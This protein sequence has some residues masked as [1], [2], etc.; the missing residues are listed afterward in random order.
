MEV[1]EA[2]IMKQKLGIKA[3]IENSPH[4]YSDQWWSIW[5][6]P[7]TFHFQ[8]FLQTYIPPILH[9]WVPPLMLSNQIFC[10]RYAGFWS[11]AI[12]MCDGRS[13]D[14]TKHCLPTTWRKLF[15]LIFRYLATATWNNKNELSQRKRTTTAVKLRSNLTSIFYIQI[16]RY[17]QYILNVEIVQNARSLWSLAY[18]TRRSISCIYEKTKRVYDQFFVFVFVAAAA[19]ECCV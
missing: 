14:R 6:T 9:L 3:S 19:A 5:S 12:Q 18:Y 16:L 11:D 10:W 7:I 1:L 13:G 8:Y 4:S 17:I 15:S 2:N